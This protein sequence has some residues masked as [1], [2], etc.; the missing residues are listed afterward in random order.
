M[1]YAITFS[2]IVLDF[3]TGMM[4]A[5][6]QGGFKSSFMRQGLYHKTGE[7]LCVV[8][9]VLIQYAQTQ[10]DIG[11]SIPAVPAICGYIILMEI[12]SCIENIGAINPDLMPDKVRK[13]LG[14]KKGDD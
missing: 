5:L 14:M 7:I 8:L 4:K 12:G 11:I 6:A 1:I 9:A 3:C 2:F 13:I 10:I